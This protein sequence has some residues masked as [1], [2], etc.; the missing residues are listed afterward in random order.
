MVAKGSVVS[1][2]RLVR[3]KR[4]RRVAWIAAS[5]MRNSAA[6][7]LSTGRKP[8]RPSAAAGIATWRGSLKRA[9]I[10]ACYVL[11]TRSHGQG[12]DGRTGMARIVVTTVTQWT[13]TLQ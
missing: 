11:S 12:F 1:G 6:R 7:T 9:F 10:V 4:E 13:A 3:F 5:A 2:A 8:K